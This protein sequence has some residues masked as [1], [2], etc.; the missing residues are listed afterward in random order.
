MSIF[1]LLRLNCG[2]GLWLCCRAAATA[3]LGL[4]AAQ[5]HKREWYHVN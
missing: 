3:P 2:Y 4:G 5:R 1:L